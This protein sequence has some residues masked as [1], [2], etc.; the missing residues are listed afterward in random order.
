MDVSVGCC[1][2]FGVAQRGADEEKR[3]EDEEGA[4]RSEDE[5]EAFA[6]KGAS[7]WMGVWWEGLAVRGGG[8]GG[9][10]E[11]GFFVNGGNWFVFLVFGGP[12]HGEQVVQACENVRL[13]ERGQLMER[14]EWG[15]LV[16]GAFNEGEAIGYV[17]ELLKESSTGKETP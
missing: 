7:V 8:A 15:K 10:F 1:G 9:G 12:R 11:I 13:V 5:E 4:A 2:G 3:E 16:D 6:G 14:R 17:Q